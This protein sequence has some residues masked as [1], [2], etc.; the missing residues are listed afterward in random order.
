MVA[1]ACALVPL[2]WHFAHD[3]NTP[4]HLIPGL[5]GL[6]CLMGLTYLG[7][8]RGIRLVG[9]DSQTSRRLLVVGLAAGLIIRILMPFTVSI[10]ENDYYRYLW[11]GA[12]TLRGWNPYGPVPAQVLTGAEPLASL[13]RD[14]GL[15]LL[16]INHPELRTVYPPVAQVF[17]ALAHLLSPFQSLG[18]RIVLLAAELA[19]LVLL[20]TLL[21][22]MDLPPT[23][24]LI[25]W[26]NPIVI[27]E[28]GNSLHMDALVP[29]FVLGALLLAHSRKLYSATALILG[30]VGLK[31]WPVLLL[32]LV[33]RASADTWPRA[34]R[35]LMLFAGGCL[36]LAAPVVLAGLNSSSG[37]SA[38]AGRWE[39][40]NGP[41]LLLIE[42][43][44]QVSVLSDGQLPPRLLFG[45]LVGSLL[46]FLVAL[47]TRKPLLH[48]DDLVR[49]ALAICAALF[50]LS[51]TQFPWYALWFIPLLALCPVRP[52]LIYSL[53]LPLYYL[54][55]Y[56]QPMGL[57]P[58]FDQ[59]VVWIEHGPIVILLAVACWH[60]RHDWFPTTQAHHPTSLPTPVSELRT[61]EGHTP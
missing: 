38:Y 55:F 52:L 24:A 37:F 53:T 47:L 41:S 11:D 2:S 35:A 5:V 26:L 36:I 17:F 10:L 15:V 59:W 16:R 57:A 6:L 32:P 30:A 61:T 22:R 56:Y 1:M 60:S 25:Y 42:L 54:R 50:L 40:N 21:R 20:L 39:M 34:I 51:P 49:R 44:R 23:Y 27:K 46:L 18:L 48:L 29:P 13:G 14:S 19:T 45:A 12:V 33:L 9:T 43:A 3:A 4:L 58:V 28:V 31:L 8:E 7:L